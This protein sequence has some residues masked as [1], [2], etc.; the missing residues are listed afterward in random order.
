MQSFKE[1]DRS[2]NDFPLSHL[3]TACTFFAA[4][5]PAPQVRLAGLQGLNRRARVGRRMEIQGG[6]KGG[7]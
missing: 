1:V 6:Y 5:D 3:Q 4:A 7:I 2:T